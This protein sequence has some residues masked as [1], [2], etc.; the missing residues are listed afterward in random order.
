[1]G[2]NTEGKLAAEIANYGQAG[3]HPQGVWPNGVLA[4]TAVGI[5]TQLLTNWARKSA[6]P[7]F[8]EYASAFSS[9]RDSSQKR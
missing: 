9:L 7:I 3:S 2:F 6:V 1:M 4:S 5:A 8:C